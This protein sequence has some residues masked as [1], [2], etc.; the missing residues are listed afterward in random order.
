MGFFEG[1]ENIEVPDYTK[2][3]R[4]DIQLSIKYKKINNIFLGDGQLEKDKDK[5]K[6]KEKGKTDP[7][8]IRL[9]NLIRE[10]LME[11]GD[12]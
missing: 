10:N 1:I 5:D 6:E 4:A 8:K 3:V 12:E 2:A 11:F 7:I 9:E